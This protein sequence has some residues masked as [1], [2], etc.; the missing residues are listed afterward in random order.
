MITE[1]LWS[2]MAWPKD[3]RKRKTLEA[4]LCS[5]SRALVSPL[6]TM[7]LARLCVDK[8][9]VKHCMTGVNFTLINQEIFPFLPSKKAALTPCLV[10]NV[11]CDRDNCVNN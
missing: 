8:H 5:S 4:V 1:S 3:D 2:R 9:T 6:S 11:W 7:V 10:G